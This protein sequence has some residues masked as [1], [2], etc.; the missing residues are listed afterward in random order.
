MKQPGEKQVS[1]RQV[2]VDGRNYV[3]MYE[4]LSDIL[5]GAG[6]EAWQS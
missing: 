6:L 5:V 2:Q 3:I 4:V 1:S